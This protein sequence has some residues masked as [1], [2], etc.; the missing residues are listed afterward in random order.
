MKREAGATS[1]Q[2]LSTKLFWTGV[3]NLIVGVKLLLT[4]FVPGLRAPGEELLSGFL[5]LVC[6]MQLLLLHSSTKPRRE[7]EPQ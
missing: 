4:F 6:T 2:A 1:P 3:I 7:E 5:L